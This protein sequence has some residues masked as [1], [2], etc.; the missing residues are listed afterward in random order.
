MLSK[1]LQKKIALDGVECVT[2][3]KGA[4]ELEYYLIESEIEN[5]SEFTGKKAFGIEII[6]KV[7]NGFEVETI[8][9]LSFCKEN[10]I[11][12]LDKLAENTVT[13]TGLTYVIDDM[14]G[15]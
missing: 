12:M 11:K 9:N 15:I 1:Y 2:E 7:E 6:K 10:T 13:P 3:V 14:M 5:S 4:I 8:K